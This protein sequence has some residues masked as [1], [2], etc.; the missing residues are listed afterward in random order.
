MEEA[1]LNEI[2]GAGWR[3]RG[4][5][6]YEGPDGGNLVGFHPFLS[7]NT[8]LSVY[9]VRFYGVSELET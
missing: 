6:R 1:G 4:R 5:M 7:R 9:G 8:I 3:K 2:C